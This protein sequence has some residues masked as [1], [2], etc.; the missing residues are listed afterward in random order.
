M[1]FQLWCAVFTGMILSIL[2]LNIVQWLTYRDRSYGFYTGYMLA[3]LCYFGLRVYTFRDWVSLETN[4]FVRA[5][6]PMGAYYVYFDFADAILDLRHR[7]P[8]FYRQLKSTQIGL[9]LYVLTQSVICYSAPVPLAL[10]ETSFVAMRLA[11]A[12]LGVYGIWQMGKLGD[13]VS[14][15]YAIGTAFLLIGGLTAMFLSMDRPGEDWNGP[16]WRVSLTYMQAGIIAEL[17]CFSLGLSYR[18]RRASIRSAMVEQELVRERERH[19]RDQLEAELTQQRL[20]QEKVEI[21]I[22][23]LQAQVNPHFLFNSLNSLSALI[24][25]KDPQRANRFLDELSSVY[26]YL[27][28]SNDRILISLRAELDFIKSYGHLLQTRHGNALLIDSQ[29]APHLLDCQ[30]PP[31]TLQL[32]VENAVKHNIALPEQPLHI[33]IRTNGRGTLQVRNNIQRKPGR[34]ISNG[35]G[36]TNIYTKYQML[37]QPRPLVQEQSGQFVVS[38]P[39]ILAD[40]PAVC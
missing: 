22:R 28:R 17:I 3:W 10:Y 35:V 34:V 6:A 7:V 21:Q 14:R 11:M 31:L 1:S 40:V 29:I 12:V 24:D 23:G 26:R 39:L 20:E 27:L 18:Q 36:L 30:L 25:D 4:L 37:N 33:Q 19:H 15:A 32:L 5:V 13:V 2:L 8:R 16:F 9:L 38:L